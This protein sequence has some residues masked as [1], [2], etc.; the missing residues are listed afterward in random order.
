MNR[1]IFIL[2]VAVVF[3]LL[4]FAEASNMG[5]TGAQFLKIDPAARPL[6]MGG[7]YSAVVDDSNAIFYNP[8]GI[9]RLENREIS[10]TY[11][12]YFQSVSYGSLAVVLPSENCVLG[13]GVNY[14]GV[15][16][17][18]KRAAID[19]DDPTGTG[20][21]DTF[22]AMDT[23]VSIVYAKGNVYEDLDVGVNMRFVYQTIDDDSAFS[24]MMDIGGFYPVND[25]LSLALGVQNIGMGVKFSDE[26]DP[27][28]L[29]LKA[30]AAYRPISNLVVSCDINE[31]IIDQVLYA[32]AGAEFWFKEM[33]GLRAGYK[34]GYDTDSL[35]SNVG[36][37]FG[38]G[39]RY[40]N[41]GI[42]YSF[43]PFGELG[44]THRISFSTKL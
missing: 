39:F 3:T 38:A 2:A 15:G 42:D 16:D 10:G 4:N 34:Y 6:G 41:M 17:I 14:L 21:V 29:N 36:L 27:L 8:A 31:Y 35:G 20:V 30:G 28:P 23:A 18:D 7:A 1:K 11:L 9:A 43:A 32:S 33:V 13:V 12:Q 26:N 22:G 44:D 24:V 19:T 5:T 25:K 37:A 40:S